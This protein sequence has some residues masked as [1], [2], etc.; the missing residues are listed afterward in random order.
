[1]SKSHL[2]RK[3]FGSILIN[4]ETIAASMGSLLIDNVPIG[5]GA[6]GISY[7]ANTIMNTI[8]SL[9]FFSDTTGNAL[10]N[11]SLY[12]TNNPSYT[13]GVGG[14]S[15]GQ[16]MTKNNNNALYLGSDTCQLTS[17]NNLTVSARGDILLY[18]PN[19]SV[20]VQTSGNLVLNEQFTISQHGT[21]I[22]AGQMNIV[23]AS[24]GNVKFTGFSKINST[25]GSILTVNAQSGVLQNFGQTIATSGS[26]TLTLLNSYIVPTSSV[27]TSVTSYAG[28][29]SPVSMVTS[30]SAGACSISINN[31]SNINPVTTNVSVG[32]FVIQ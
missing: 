23:G 14:L 6:S 5:S 18:G 29:G 17:N 9:A 24:V 21:Y 31:V 26:Q 10:S 12:Y 2:V 15:G 8:G 28:V 20:N 11:N 13:F 1:M 3:E 27:L 30:Q 19:S 22:T 4:T 16:I 7:T 25:G 32:F